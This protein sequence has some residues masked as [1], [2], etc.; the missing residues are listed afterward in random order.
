MINFRIE[1]IWHGDSLT[2]NVDTNGSICHVYSIEDDFGNVPDAVDWDMIQTIETLA[3]CFYM[4]E[5]A[6]Y[7]LNGD[8]H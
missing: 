8:I 5:Q 1:F 2:A 7:Y 6:T 3:I 4:D